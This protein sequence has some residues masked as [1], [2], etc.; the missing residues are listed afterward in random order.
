MTGITG[1]RFKDSL[2]LF[3][4][5]DTTIQIPVISTNR[6][7]ATKP[8]IVI[9]IIRRVIVA[10]GDAQ[11]VIVIVP[12]PAAQDSFRHP[13]NKQ[14]IWSILSNH[15][16]TCR[17]PKVIQGQIHIA[18][19]GLSQGHGLI[20]NKGA[21]CLTLNLPFARLR[22]YSA[23]KLLP[24]SIREIKKGYRPSAL[25]CGN[26]HFSEISQYASIASA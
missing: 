20:A 10:V 17:F 16:I 1:T 3:S 26:V 25:P 9:G 6:S 21:V 15:P 2:E 7:R 12:R 24:S 18:W 8:D 4:L 13:Q 5:E 11:I 22:F 23:H 14:V 19:F